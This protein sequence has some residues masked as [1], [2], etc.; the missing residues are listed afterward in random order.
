[1]TVASCKVLRVAPLALVGFLAACS[2]PPPPPPPTVV[3]LTFS[4]A[5][6]VN[7]DPSGRA[8]PI[9]VRY[10][11][12]GATGAFEK[13]DYFQIHD[14]EAALLGPDL[15]DRQD[16]AVTPGAVQK[17]SLEAKPSTKSLGVIASY[18]DIDHAVWR[19]DVPIP[20][21]QT[22]KLKVRLDK[23]T[24]SITPEEK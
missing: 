14:K 16:L 19:A 24:L 21:N 22:T 15:F 8:S 5:E 11:Q 12:L 7:P 13:A 20:A 23:L 10:Y 1:M 3:E 4:A 6:D 17:V 9:I 18:R 2:S